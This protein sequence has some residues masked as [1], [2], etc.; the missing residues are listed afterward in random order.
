MI[1]TARSQ[2]PDSVPI[3]R[4]PRRV[5]AADHEILALVQDGRV[6]SSIF[7]SQEIFELEMQNIFHR[8]WLYVG[9]ES[10]VPD[11]GDFKLRAIGRQPVILVRGHDRVVRVLMN[12]CRHRGSVVCEE[13][14]GQTRFFR[15]WYHGWVYDNT[16]KNVQVSGADGY[17]EAFRKEDHDLSPVPRMESYRGFVFASTAREGSSLREH[18][19]RSA[20]MIDIMVDASPVGEILVD[21]GCYKTEFKGNWKLVGMD[22]YH[23]H[24]THAS[25]IDA[26]EKKAK[27]ESDWAVT[28][29]GDPFGD[30]SDSLTRDLGN[31]HAMLDFTGHRLQHL[32]PYLAIFRKKTPGAAEYVERM[33]SRYGRERGDLLIAL[34]GDPHAGIYPNLQII[35]NQLRVINPLAV[36]RAEIVMYAVR[37]KGVSEAINTARLRAHEQFFGPAGHGS[38]DDNEVFERVQRGM[39]AQVDPWIDISRGIR[40]QRLEADGSIVGRI[41]DEVPQRAQMRQWRALMSEAA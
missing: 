40:R 17:D 12:R 30:N 4:G 22:G 6:H 3:A 41:T 23:P 21:A 20:P 16:G 25:I 39:M 8:T 5:K 19:G 36:D 2:S 32:E 24:F 29:L 15:C 35:N 18:L 7:T 26:H 10:E 31:G 34:A 1:E 28:H 11:P 9:H 27:T 38:P 33:R 13:A 14:E 37:L